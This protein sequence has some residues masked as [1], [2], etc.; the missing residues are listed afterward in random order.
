MDDATEAANPFLGDIGPAAEP[1]RTQTAGAFLDLAIRAADQHA[2]EEPC[3]W[4]EAHSAPAVNSTGFKNGDASHGGVS[5]VRFGS[6]KSGSHRLE[7]VMSPALWDTL[8]RASPRAKSDGRVSIEIPL[9]HEV[10]GRV[11]VVFSAR[12]NL[13]QMGLAAAMRDAWRALCHLH[14]P[15]IWPKLVSGSEG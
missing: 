9:G 10:D 1:R 5:S 2:I 15:G 3:G 7:L 6:P 14:Y 13:E 4:P 11:D 8:R 12:G